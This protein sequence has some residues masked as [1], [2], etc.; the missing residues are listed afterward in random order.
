MT[1]PV[2]KLRG[3]PREIGRQHGEQVPE[4]IKDNLRFYMNLW[5]HMGGVSREKILTDVEAFIPFI[6]RFDPELI[7]EMKGVADGAGLEF[8]GRRPERPHRA[9]LFLS[10]QYADGIVRRRVHLF[11]PYAGRD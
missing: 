7:E 3:T 5:Q 4:L 10:T 6:E 9:D 2:L 11:R 1:V 8:R